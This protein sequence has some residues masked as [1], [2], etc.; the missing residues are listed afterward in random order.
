ML[1]LSESIPFL[2]QASVFLLQAE[3][4]GH[5][6]TLMQQLEHSNV[7]NVALVVL[8]L[9]FLAKKFNLLGGIE[10]QRKQL[11]SGIEAVELQKKQALQQLE[12]AQ[13]KTANLTAEVD[14]IL[15]N[16]RQSAEALSKQILNDARSESDKIIENAKR[17]VELEQRSA[18][19]DLERR[20][21]SDALSD[22]RVALA[23]DLNAA[24]QKRSIETFLDEL[25][26]LKEGHRS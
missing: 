7:F 9:G 1:P 19:K 17:R 25:S 16:A 24:D 12:E 3:G 15:N 6:M 14:E 13:R 20:L 8:I 21:L 11:A 22:A 5:S 2:R 23:G 4:H 10:A 18:I 26:Q